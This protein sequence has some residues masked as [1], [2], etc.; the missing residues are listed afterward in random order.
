MLISQNGGGHKNSHLL[1][2]ARSLEGRTHSHLG[3]AKAY[4]TANKPVHRPAA[5]HVGLNIVSGLQLVGRVLIYKT[6]F[7]LML[8]KR[9]GTEGIALFVSARRI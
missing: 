3:L 8:H 1:R 6:G 5:L 9:V 4:V 2:V 7:K